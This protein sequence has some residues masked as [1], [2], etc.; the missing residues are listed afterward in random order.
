MKKLK[1]YTLK[2]YVD[3]LAQRTP[4]P[5]GGS[6]AAY[7]A[8]LA[9][10][11]IGMVAAYSKGRAVSRSV[12]N[13]IN[14]ISIQSKE[15]YLRLLELVDEDAQS[16]LEVVKSRKKPKNEQVKALNC[17]K[18]VPKEICRLSYKAIGQI[19]YL[20]KFGNKYLISDLEVAAE[21]L[22]SSHRSASIL[23]Q[24]NS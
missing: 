9:V 11:L 13:R 8:C 6:V 3:V 5:G 1:N 21:L 20:I 14:K 24:A 7:S 23:Y 4:V 18:K 12:E 17:A 10:G 15:I 16:Y 2:N 22:L 19:E